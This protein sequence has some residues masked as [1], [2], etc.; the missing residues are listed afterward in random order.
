MII[1]IDFDGTL[2]WGE[3]PQ[4]GIVARGAVEHIMKLRQEGHY[5]IIWTCRQGDLLTEA[6]NWLLEKG[7]P[8]NRINDNSPMNKA[9]FG[10]NTRKVNADIYIDDRQIGGLP[11]WSQI[12]EYVKQESLK[13]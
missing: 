5:I 8:F 10:G 12:Y 2:H 3:Y 4:I 9:E 7:I 11:D 6:V 1:A 13:K